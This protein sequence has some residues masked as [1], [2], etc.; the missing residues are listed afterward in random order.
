MP[1]K[2]LRPCRYPGCTDL[3]RS[4]Y[5][6]RHRP[7]RTYDSRRGTATE[8]GYNSK[9]SRASKLFLATHPWCAECL[10]R[11]G[12]RVRATET[13]HIIPH[14]GDRHL[15]WDQSNW[16]PLCHSCHSVKT[17]REDG[18]FGNTRIPPPQKK[19]G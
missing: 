9:W 13:D 3:V 7:T 8:R 6:D 18:G 2:P 15:F 4:G 19:L 11:D 14:K 12:I 16:Q 1:T 10:R 17:A 5:C